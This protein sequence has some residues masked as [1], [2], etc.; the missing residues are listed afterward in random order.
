[1]KTKKNIIKDLDEVLNKIKEQLNS[2]FDI[3]DE[4]YYK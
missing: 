3:L 4:F 1:M 2:N